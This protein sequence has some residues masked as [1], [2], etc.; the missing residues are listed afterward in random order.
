MTAGLVCITTFNSAAGVIGP[1]TG[2]SCPL[3][4]ALITQE[5]LTY[6]IEGIEMGSEV[7]VSV[8][9]QS[10][11]NPGDRHY[12]QRI[13]ITV[14][15]FILLSNLDEVEQLYL[16]KCVDSEHPNRNIESEQF[17]TDL[18]TALIS[19]EGPL[20]NI[21]QIT[22]IT[23]VEKDIWAQ[24]Y[25]EIGYT[26]V[27]TRSMHTVLKATPTSGYQLSSK[28][29][30]QLLGANFGLF[31]EYGIGAGNPSGE[32]FFGNIEV[33]P[34]ISGY[35]WGRIFVGRNM[36][37]DL[38][39]RLNNQKIQAPIIEVN[40]SWLRVGHVDEIVIF[41]PASDTTKGFKM[42]IASPQ[43]A[44]DIIGAIEPELQPYTIITGTDWSSQL[45][46]LITTTVEALL[47]GGANTPEYAIRKSNTQWIQPKL[48]QIRGQ[49]KKELKLDDS[50][51]IDIPVLFVGTVQ[52]NDPENPITVTS[53]SSANAYS[54]NMI[55]LL[56]VNDHLV[57]PDPLGPISDG[58]DQFKDAVE[59]SLDDFDL[60]LDFIYNWVYHEAKGEIHCGTN[61][62]RVIPSE[63]INWWQKQ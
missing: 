34:P 46:T 45:G 25:S 57:I 18:A 36:S 15:P 3:N 7:I 5:P 6:G 26:S 20:T 43:K 13:P 2:S 47:T 28:I 8:I 24:D 50:D 62:K 11:S 29:N 41:V 51:I 14:S 54:P 21:D 48:N 23:D 32:D 1:E 35:P 61:A 19:T 12:C 33:T 52:W 40:T 63:L 17:I 53:V 22:V 39:R 16:A 44:M 37:D 42:L 9:A 30:D 4:G 56:V 38:K 27:P 10:K 60:H 59:S 31:P 58:K 55:N 49:F